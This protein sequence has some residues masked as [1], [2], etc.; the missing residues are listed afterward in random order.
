V[1]RLVTTVLLASSVW[2][3]A[4]G[5]YC[6]AVH[7]PSFRYVTPERFFD[8]TVMHRG[9]TGLLVGPPLL[10]Q[11]LATF[12]LFAFLGRVPGWALAA[13]AACLVFS[14]GWTGVVSGPL[15]GQ[16]AMAGPD[17]PLIQRLIDSCWVRNLAWTLQAVLAGW[18]LFLPES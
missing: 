3:A 8:F 12:A 16:I 7:Y 17:S 18:L 14:V 10:L 11:I 2:M 1:V 13:S 15:H 5:I 4:V 6:Q 9:M